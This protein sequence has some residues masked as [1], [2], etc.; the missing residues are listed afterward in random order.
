MLKP[1]RESPSRDVVAV[2][3]SKAGNK[4]ESTCGM[5]VA[6]VEAA[7]MSGGEAG[8]ETPATE[9]CDLMI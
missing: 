8:K 1:V 2:G 9:P 4:H 5:I 7:P 6:R 3:Q